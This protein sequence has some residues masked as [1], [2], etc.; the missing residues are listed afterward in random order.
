MVKT[1]EVISSWRVLFDDFNTSSI[2]FYN[3]VITALKRRE[4]PDIV[5]EKVEWNESGVLSAKRLY[6]RVRRGHLMFDICAAPFGKGFFISWWLAGPAPAFGLLL[7]LGF[8]V[9]GVAPGFVGAIVTAVLRQALLGSALSMI[10]LI[11]SPVALLFLVN[12]G[13]NPA[14]E[15]AVLAL[16]II[17]P[18]YRALF[19]PYSYFRQDTAAMFQESVR[20]AVNEA[21]DGLTQRQGLRALSPEE[22]IPRLRDLAR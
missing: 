10:A 21:I 17:G 18:L 13:G 16:P 15:Q 9:I 19:N 20:A 5:Y 8:L 1:G 14:I 3:S 12:T 4:V 6:L 22:R 7:L 11:C 2:A